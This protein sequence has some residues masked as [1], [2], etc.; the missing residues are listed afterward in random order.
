M[1]SARSITV[2]G[3][4][5]EGEVGRVITGGVLPPPGDSLFAQREY[6][7][8]Q[9]D[10]LRKFLLYEPR[11]GAFVHSNLVVPAKTPGAAA[12]FIIM[13]PTDYPAMSGSNAICVATVLLETGMVAM[14]EPETVLSLDTPGGL[15]EVVAQC[16]DGRCLNVRIGNVPCFVAKLDAAVEVAGLGTIACDIAYGGAF[17]AIV[18]AP[19]LGFALVPDEARELVEMGERIKA[20]AVA[21][22]PVSHP[23]NP[24]I[25][26]VT[27]TQFAAPLSKDAAGRTVG[28]NTV[29]IS[30]GKLD[31]S[32]CGTGSSARLA[33]LHARGRIGLGETLIS[34]SVLGTEFHCRIEELCAVGDLP[35]ISPSVQGRAWI[36]GSH[37][38][39]LDPDDPFPQGYTLSDTWYRALD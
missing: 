17:F 20:A 19:G 11:G 29:V 10:G 14:Q 3:C 25:H 9:D 39:S 8:T 23:E 38:Y 7:R 30:P 37:Q 16:R 18:D 2:I 34:Q 24:D 36:T 4:H 33:V 32:S 35:A 26:S 21:Q 13:E 6:L 27:F 31:R 12:G 5:A 28:R 15:I 1:R 22:H